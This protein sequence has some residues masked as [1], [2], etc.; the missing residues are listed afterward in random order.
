[1]DGPIERCPGKPEIP[2]GICRK[3]GAGRFYLFSMAF[4]EFYFQF[5]ILAYRQLMQRIFE[6]ETKF[7]FRLQNALPGVSVT[8]RK[9]QTG[10][11]LVHLL[12]YVGSVRPLEKLPELRGLYL[13]LP[14][15]WKILTDLR[16][17]EEYTRHDS[18]GFLLP[19]LNDFAVY[20]VRN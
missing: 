19:P 10:N 17:G 13:F 15:E 9:T 16:T 7:A 18:G 8:I 4:F 2:V 3:V 5:Q 12:N 11:L 14:P 6:R 1:M 20:T